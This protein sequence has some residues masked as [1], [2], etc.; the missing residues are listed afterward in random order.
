MHAAL[1]AD[2][3]AAQL[4]ANSECH[5]LNAAGSAARGPG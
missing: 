5:A 4:R 1:S 2:V 3:L